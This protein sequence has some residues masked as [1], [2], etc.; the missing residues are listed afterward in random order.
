MVRSRFFS[1]SVITIKKRSIKC[2]RDAIFLNKSLNKASIIG[3]LK[4][5]CIKNFRGIQAQMHRIG[6][7]ISH[8][9]ICNRITCN[10]ICAQ[11]LACRKKTAIFK[12]R[13]KRCT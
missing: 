5:H 10:K 1:P 7:L 11:K 6:Q 4:I 13:S 3:R 2:Q 8:L 12:L 9:S